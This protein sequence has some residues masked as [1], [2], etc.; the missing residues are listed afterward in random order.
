MQFLRWLRGALTLDFGTSLFIGK[1]VSEALLDRA[2]PTL[3][4]TLYALTFSI[5]FGIPAGVLAA[6]RPGSLLDR[7]IMVVAVSGAALPSF[8]VS[9]MLILVFAVAWRWLPS[10]GFVELT[11][12]PAE[13]VR[14]MIL[15][16]LALGFSSAGILARLVR[17]TL[18]E[19]LREDFVRT[20]R[21]KGLTESIVIM[22]HAL[23]NALIPAV[24]MIGYSMAGL[25]G[26]AVVTETVFNIP[27]MGRLV[28]QSIARRDLAVIQ[29]AVMLTAAVYLFC[30]LVVDVLYACLDP[31]VR[32]GHD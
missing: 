11:L 27:G 16:A 26:G 23:R 19:V 5:A 32:Y 22:R 15:P 2:Q 30:N 25:L 24:T 29:G 6:L 20:A 12:D 9:I 13:H 17:S 14:T 18:L 7:A 10:G 31:R 21:A 4:L 28:V 8:F 3:L 1:P